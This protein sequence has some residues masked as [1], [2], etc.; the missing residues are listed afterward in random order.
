MKYF[1]KI[2]SLLKKMRNP[3]YFVYQ[4]YHYIK[5][6]VPFVIAQYIS[7][8][9]K[10]SLA[11]KGIV[12]KTYDGSDQ[13]CHPDMTVF[14]KKFWITMTPYPYGMDEYE[15]PIVYCGEKFEDLLRQV[16]KPLDTPTIREYGYHLSDPCIA[17][18]GQS[19]MLLYRESRRNKKTHTDTNTLYLCQYDAVT[20]QWKSS[21]T[22]SSSD[23]MQFLSPAII[24]CGERTY[25]Y[26]AEFEKGQLLLSE[27]KDCK[28]TEPKEI[29]V[30]GMPLNYYVWHLTIAYKLNKVKYSEND[31]ALAGVF[32]VRSK[33]N[34]NHFKLVLA[35]SEGIGRDWEISE[36]ISIPDSI[37]DMV[38][39]VYKSAFLPFTE[40]VLI[41]YRDKSD[42][43]CF[44]KAGRD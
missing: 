11:D 41:S 24:N 8:K 9:N 23:E 17:E 22:L 38:K 30:L 29:K 34:R 2:L 43:Y 35:S 18:T 40:D 27:I 39:I 4:F 6:D 12:F 44:I 20:D 1:G 28:L 37:K 7:H 25:C 26:F 14:N 42:R 33:D 21:E 31:S 10:N 16:C 13:A 19:L 15:N 3:A 36:E 32:L 5:C